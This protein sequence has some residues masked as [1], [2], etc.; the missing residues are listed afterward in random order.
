M[1]YGYGSARYVMR[2]GDALEFEGDVPHGP[3][4]LTKLPITFLSVIATGVV[5]NADPSHRYHD[6]G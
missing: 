4:E 5:A 2:P 3:V 1:T 6:R